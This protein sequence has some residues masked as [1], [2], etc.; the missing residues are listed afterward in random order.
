MYTSKIDNPSE[1]TATELENAWLEDASQPASLEAVQGAV[2]VK[3]TE[4]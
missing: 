2:A 4:E 3:L 1:S